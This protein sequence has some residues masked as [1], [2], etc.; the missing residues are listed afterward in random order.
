MIGLVPFAPGG[1]EVAVELPLAGL[2]IAGAR[3]LLRLTIGMVTERGGQQARVPPLWR[4]PLF[5][6]GPADNLRDMLPQVRY[7]PPE[8]ECGPPVPGARGTR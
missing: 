7:G 4:I 1:A 3:R 2:A 6:D 5:G 8:E